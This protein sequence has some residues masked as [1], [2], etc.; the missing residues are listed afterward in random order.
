MNLEK[1]FQVLSAMHPLSADFKDQLQKDTTELSLPKSYHLLEAPNIADHA[2]FLAKGFALSYSYV[3]G[4]K[5]IEQLWRQGDIILPAKSLFERTPSHEFIILVEPSEVLY[6]HHDSIIRLL[7]TFEE[8]RAINRIV[9][10]RYYELYRERLRDAHSQSA[11]KRYQ[12][13]IV[14]FPRIEQ[15]LPQEHI[16]SYLGITPQSLSRIKKSM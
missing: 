11:E 1:L 3:N 7:A 4:K 9:M 6:I 12:K 8:A 15:L 14:Q 16:A 10:N 2:Y 13:L 5:L